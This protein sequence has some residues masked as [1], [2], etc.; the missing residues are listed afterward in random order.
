[1]ITLAINKDTVPQ[2]IQ[3]RSGG[4]GGANLTNPTA[5]L[6]SAPFTGEDLIKPSHLD[7]M[8][9]GLPEYWGWAIDTPNQHWNFRIL[10]RVKGVHI[11]HVS[12]KQIGV[13]ENRDDLGTA[14]YGHP[15]FAAEPGAAGGFHTGDDLY[16]K[17][18]RDLEYAFF[19]THVPNAGDTA[20]AAVTADPDDLPDGLD[21]KFHIFV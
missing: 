10:A 21:I 1:M 17:I 2:T 18:A 20:R 5:G 6:L 3:F 14:Y 12:W 11:R 4:Q 15:A 8:R 16:L 13:N 7:S 19:V 9:V